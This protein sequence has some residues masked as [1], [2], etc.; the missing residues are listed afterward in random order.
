[1]IGC[2]AA[3]NFATKLQHPLLS[4]RLSGV[5][6]VA[7]PAANSAPR[8]PR[9]LPDYRYLLSPGAVRIFTSCALLEV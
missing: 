5:D 9:C 7:E 1:M 4:R 3:T 2:R 6:R 8:V